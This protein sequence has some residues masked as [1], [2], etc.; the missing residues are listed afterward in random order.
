M[1][2]RRGLQRWRVEAFK[3]GL[4]GGDISI[5]ANRSAC[6]GVNHQR[7]AG[8]QVGIEAADGCLRQGRGSFGHAEIDQG[9]KL[10]RVR[11]EV[12]RVRFGRLDRG[13]QVEHG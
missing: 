4:K 12:E 6:A 3:Q 11:F 9:I 10:Q 5:R 8:P 2:G 13:P 7:A 1:I